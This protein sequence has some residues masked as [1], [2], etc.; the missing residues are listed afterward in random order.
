M[1]ERTG[2][3]IWSDNGFEDAREIHCGLLC[4]SLI[5][6]LISFK[7]R[8][9]PSPGGGSLYFPT[10]RQ[11]RISYEFTEAFDPARINHVLEA[12]RQP[13]ERVLK[14]HFCGE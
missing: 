2:D 9:A 13:F 8:R 10:G 7:A 1:L 4:H 11:N 3:H 5:A 12:R 6:Q 14:W